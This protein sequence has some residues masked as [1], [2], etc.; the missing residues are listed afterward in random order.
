MKARDVMTPSVI[1][2]EA[3]EPVMRAVR[4]MLQNR[5]SG[6]PVTDKNGRLVGIVTE[7]DFLRRGELGTER[8]RPR[9]LEFLIGPGRLATEYVRARGSKV[10]EIMTPDPH[11]ICEDTPLDQIVQSMEKHQIKRLPV[12]KDGKLVGIVSR[13][14]LMHALASLA[15]EVKPGA[16]DDAVLRR[17]ILD[18]FNKQPRAP[19]INVV[20]RDGVA[21]LWGVILDE[22]ER[23]AFIVA[24]E[25]V[26]GVKA[27]HDHLVWVEPMSGMAFLADEDKA[28]AAAS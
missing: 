5:I 8:R 23:Q 10:D 24:A 20:V 7:G 19:G 6:L 3:G 1:S 21:E 13:A 22:R 15:P 9:W 12:V 26:R 28:S 17:Q 14:N 25:N 27:V 11:T 18:E 2:V 4:L 16:S